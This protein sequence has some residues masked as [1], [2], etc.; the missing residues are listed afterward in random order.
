MERAI[1]A[2]LAKL[3][4]QWRQSQWAGSSACSNA[5]FT[6]PMLALFPKTC[7]W[8]VLHSWW[9]AA[10]AVCVCV[11]MQVY[12]RVYMCMCACTCMCVRMQVHVCVYVCTCVCACVHACVRACVHAR[13]V[14]LLQPTTMHASCEGVCKCLRPAAAQI[15]GRLWAWQHAHQ[16]KHLTSRPPTHYVVPTMWH[17]MGM[18]IPVAQM[19]G[20]PWAWPACPKA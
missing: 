1:V 2:P 15:R 8:M 14:S 4:L 17:P 20:R 6:H 5:M 19:R 10:G 16:S 18:P 9:A 7:F 12:V 13:A 3:K 11:C